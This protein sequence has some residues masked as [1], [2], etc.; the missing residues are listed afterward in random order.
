MSEGKTAW[1]AGGPLEPFDEAGLMAA[2]DLVSAQGLDE[3]SRWFRFLVWQWAAKPGGVAVDFRCP[4]G[5]PEADWTAVRYVASRVHHWALTS[6]PPKMP[7]LRVWIERDNHSLMLG[8]RGMTR[9]E[10]RCPYLGESYYASRLFADSIADSGPLEDVL[11]EPLHRE[12]VLACRRDRPR[13]DPDARV[14]N[15]AEHFDELSEMTRDQFDYLL[16]RG[17]S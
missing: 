11:F 12:L 16:G 8:G 1:P 6:I 15:S 10:F 4:P 17:A 2:T 7:R 14:E 13:P 3:L 5:S 9:L